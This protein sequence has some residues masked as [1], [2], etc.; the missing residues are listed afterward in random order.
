MNTVKY[1]FTIIYKNLKIPMVL[2]E[3]K[4]YSVNYRHRLGAHLPY[5][6][7]TQETQENQCAL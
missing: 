3:A 7:Q 6:V 1:F 2:K 5:T 4:L